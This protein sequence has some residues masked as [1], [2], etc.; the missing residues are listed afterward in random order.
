VAETALSRILN[1]PSTAYWRDDVRG[2]IYAAAVALPMGL[3]FGVVSGLGPVAGIYGAVFTGLCAA[4]F[5]GTP[6]QIAGPTGPIAIVIATVT[7]G[8][9]DRPGAVVAV[10]LLA[11]VLQ[12]AFGTLKLGQYISLIPYPV[13]AGF[14]SGVGCIIIVMQMNP[15]LGFPPVHDTVTAVRL[16]PGHLAAPNVTATLIALSCFAACRFMPARLR[17]LAPV[18]LSVLMIGTASVTALGL[19]VPRLAEP[20]S[21]LPHPAFPPLGSLPWRDVFVTALVLALISSLDSLMTSIAADS[22]TQRVHDSE[23]ELVGQGIGN[24][25]AGLVG[26]MPGAGSTFRTMANI[27]GG[28]K[29]PL[30]AMM[31][32]LVLLVLLLAFGRL[33]RFIPS[34]VLAG[35]LIY[36]GAGIIDWSYIRR[37]PVAPRG[38]VVIMVI[39]WLVAVFI[40]VVTAVA[41]G[42]I[43]ASLALVKRM[44]DLQLESVDTHERAPIRAL[45]AVERAAFDRSNG[46]TLLIPLSG[47]L[48]FAAATGLTRRLTGVTGYRTIILDFTDVP[49]IDESAV[50]ALENIIR[51]ARRNRREVLLVGL[52]TAVVREIVRFGLLPRVRSCPRFARRLDALERAAE[53]AARET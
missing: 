10:I 7:V 25:I 23:R 52:R 2:G 34:S 26:A 36:I 5:G 31:H 14:A 8:F 27:R 13:I 29:T 6:T 43:M 16:L 17:R 28:G 11:G 49:L 46:K 22:A 32:S 20:T 9:A 40:N 18:H 50:H 45:G 42:M 19:D 41:I 47:A 48:T 21:L 1:I 15:L 4:L 39:V 3:A 30:S 35:I 44:A 38:G 51:G 33:I 24:L 12:L 37:F 53:I